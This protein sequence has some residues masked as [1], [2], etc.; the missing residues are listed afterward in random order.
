MTILMLPE[1]QLDTDNLGSVFDMVL[2][3]G[4][5]MIP[6]GLCSV[7]AMAYIVERW[8]RLS[9]RSLGVAR[10]PRELL[11]E[12][13]H[14]GAEKG[15]ALCQSASSPM[16]RALEPAFKRNGSPRLEV[17]KAVED[18]GSREVRRL[19]GNLRP[20]VVVAVIAPLLGLLGT[21]WGMIQ[22]FQN[23]ALRD[24]IGKPELL[25]EGISQALITTA[26]GLAVAI[27]TQAAY[28]WFRAKIDKFAHSAE[29]LYLDVEDTL[30]TGV[31][32]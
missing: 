14:G 13:S 1:P 32:A 31:A 6:I 12:L 29:H 2:A 5:L 30:G 10:F 21:V 18:A 16:A 26:A 8:I 17:E 7:I 22:A 23:I 20:L 24:A 25:A 4:P 19:S 11:A 28:Y 27:P 15:L 9:R 3:G